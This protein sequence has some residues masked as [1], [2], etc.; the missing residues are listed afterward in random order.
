MNTCRVED[1]DRPIYLKRDSLCNAHYLQLRKGKPFTKP[2][3]TTPVGL[4]RCSFDGCTKMQSAKGYCVGHYW[5]HH[6]GREMKPLYST[7]RAR[8]SALVRDEQG[9]KECTWCKEWR[10]ESEY[11][12]HDKNSDGLRAECSPCRRKHYRD[13]RDDF[14]ARRIEAFFNITIEERDD[15][16]ESQ[17]GVCACCGTDKPGSKGWCIDHDHACCPESGRSCGSCIRGILC[18]RCNLVLGSVEDRTDT[19]SSM[20]DYLSA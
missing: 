18:S 16:L 14:I 2:R 1:C 7:M 20:I 13:N 6:Q 15:I 11:G 19:L 17:G 5:M 9:N 4:E 10:P 8:G 12:P 3:N